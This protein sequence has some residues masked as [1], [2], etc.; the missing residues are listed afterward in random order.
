MMDWQVN[1]Q[2]SRPDAPG[3]TAPV[4]GSQLD[5]DARSRSSK[6]V[7]QVQMASPRAWTLWLEYTCAQRVPIQLR[8]LQAS[9]QSSTQRTVEFLPGQM[10][11]MVVGQTVTVDVIGPGGATGLVPVPAVVTCALT[12]GTATLL[13]LAGQSGEVVQVLPAVA[14]G[15]PVAGDLG[16]TRLIH[17][18]GPGDIEYEITPGITSGRILANQTLN[19]PYTGP[20]VLIDVAGTAPAVNV[21]TIKA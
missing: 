21:T 15:T 1:P 14:P 11:I 8:I 17:N 12:P 7:I 3:L 4:W 20:L 5:W 16:V 6:R 9:G 10:P 2:D 19:L 18:I 13:P